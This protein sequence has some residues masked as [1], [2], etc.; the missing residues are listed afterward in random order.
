M[1]TASNSQSQR[2][3]KLHTALAFN[4]LSLL[5]FDGMDAVNECF[6]YHVEAVTNDETVA[7]NLDDLLGTHMT[8]QLEDLYGAQK[9]FDGIV[10]ECGWG[11]DGDTGNVYRFTLRPWFWVMSKRRNNKIYQNK[12][13]EAIINE[14]C[15]DFG[16]DAAGGLDVQLSG[17]MPLANQEYIVQ[18]DES[19][20]HFLTRLMERYGV[21]YFFKHE[22]GAHKM[23]ITDMVD[24]FEQLQPTSREYL[25][26]E[27]Q[28]VN[29]A[30]HFWDWTPHRRLTTGKVALTDYNFKTVSANMKGE[31]EGD[32]VHE[33]GKLESYE[34]PGV[35][36]DGSEGS[37]YAR[38]R[39]EQYRARDKHHTATGDCISLS[40]GM[41]FTLEG[42]HQD[43]SLL[44]QE[45]IC[46][47]AMHSFSTGGYRSSGS[48]SGGSEH[49]FVGNYEFAPSAVPYAPERKT[50]ETR[51]TG[52]Q[53]ATVVG[54]GGEEIDVDEFGRIVVQF[55]W[56]RLGSKD[57]KSSMRIRV[58]QPWAGAGWG[59]LFI[60]R[61][62]M[63]VIVEFLEGDPNKPVVTGC[64]YNGDNAPPYEQPGD[65]NWNGIKSNS[66]LGGGGYNELVF[67][68]TKGDELFRQH[69]QYDMETKVLN[70][71]RREVDVNRTTTIGGN[72][73]RTVHGEETHTI[74]KDN[75]YLI[76][77]DENRTVNKNRE[78]NID[79][80][81]TLNVG[82]NRLT[83]VRG[84]STLNA[85]SDIEINSLTK[86]T[87]KV[88]GSSITIEP[89]KISLSSIEIDASAAGALKTSGGGTAEHK[90]GGMMTIQAALVKIN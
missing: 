51:M 26:H 75:T 64:V 11:G 45:Y 19:D 68:D 74:D 40:S 50:R 56:D 90:S 85:Q 31:Q 72:E 81:E 49:V 23:V 18:Y 76:K 52:P 57:E 6:E 88:G 3:G 1:S 60:P 77:G 42:N 87:L 24:G 33:Y 67:N 54:A 69:A 65:K 47:R 36:L 7:I 43:E 29:E 17:A 28:H 9:Y 48:G 82:G 89:A 59:T 83:E 58:A 46:T 8:V 79:I 15:S 5:R 53:T 20:F 13:F 41:R 34:Y 80:D 66:T 4:D 16:N 63:E 44:G 14:V 2:L 37:D 32:A 73:T 86:I 70:D 21:N 38:I 39:A 35:Y 62:G 61:I 84:T 71:E 55:H 30:E 78:T 25:I 10:T 22:Q 12:S 27:G